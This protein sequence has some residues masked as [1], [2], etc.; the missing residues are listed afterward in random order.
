MGFVYGSDQ[1]G[2]SVGWH[3]GGMCEINL[4]SRSWIR[5]RESAAGEWLWPKLMVGC[6]LSGIGQLSVVILIRMDRM[7]S[8]EEVN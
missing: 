5:L 7:E 4:G 3:S 1:E 2:Q 6:G 8:R